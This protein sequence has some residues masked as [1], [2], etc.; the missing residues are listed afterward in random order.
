MRK[1]EKTESLWTESFFAAGVAFVPTQEKKNPY[2]PGGVGGQ[3]DPP[4]C[5][6]LKNVSSKKRVKPGFL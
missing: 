4:P 1:R 2:L 3:I 5:G 6:F